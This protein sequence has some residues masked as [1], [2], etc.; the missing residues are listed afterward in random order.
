MTNGLPSII[1]M[2]ALL[3]TLSS[4]PALSQNI[5]V[6]TPPER[7]AALRS[8][9]TFDPLSDSQLRGA[10]TAFL[11][12]SSKGVESVDAQIGWVVGGQSL[13][14]SFSTP[15]DKENVDTRIADVDGLANG[16]SIALSFGGIRVGSGF[17]AEDLPKW[18]ER[19]RM[20]GLIPSDTTTINC[21]SFQRG[22]L[23]EHLRD[24]YDANSVFRRGAILWGLTAKVGRRT[25]EYLQGATLDSAKD[26]RWGYNVGMS[27]G[28]TF[29]RGLL[30]G[31]LGYER[32]FKAS[33]KGQL[34]VPLIGST[35]LQ[36]QEAIFAGPSEK[37]GVYF[38]LDFKRY[39]TSWLATSPRVVYKAADKNVVAA[40]PF[41]FLAGKDGLV[42]GISPQWSSKD[43]GDVTL[44]VG[45]AFGLTLP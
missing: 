27:A 12:T 34:C 29:A 43:K 18:C 26:T 44:F 23:P 24:D 3:S 15:L 10:N 37:H 7:A 16:T 14:L 19:Q 32:S 42:G 8:V 20:S 39:V 17:N 40:F 22:E 2:V 13:A 5:A 1:R 31:G 45:K 41:Y 21:D 38:R 25:F 33:P 30:S 4:L 35:A 6:P 28:P 11:F 9:F 36:C